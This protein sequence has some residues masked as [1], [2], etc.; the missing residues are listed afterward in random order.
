MIQTKVH[1]KGIEAEN[2][3]PDLPSDNDYSYFRILTIF[4]IVMID[5]HSNDNVLLSLRLPKTNS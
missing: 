5:N 1:D 2:V 3:P 4:Q